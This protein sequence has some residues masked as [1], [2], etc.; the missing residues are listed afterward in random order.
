MVIVGDDGNIGAVNAIGIGSEK[1][2]PWMSVFYKY[3]Q[4][5]LETWHPGFHALYCHKLGLESAILQLLPI[6]THLSVIWQFKVILE[7]LVANRDGSDC[8]LQ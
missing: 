5:S 8:P 6:L 4:A 1:R 3:I 2:R 7:A